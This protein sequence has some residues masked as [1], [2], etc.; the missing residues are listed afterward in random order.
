MSGV[1]LCAMGAYWTGG[2][3]VKRW[4]ENE[5]L[6]SAFPNYKKILKHNALNQYN[7]TRSVAC[8]YIQQQKM[9]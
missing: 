7:I 3:E 6:P 5:L 2:Q 1:A 9:H 8:A 4:A